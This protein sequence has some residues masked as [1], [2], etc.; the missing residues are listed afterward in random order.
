MLPILGAQVVKK[1]FA[2]PLSAGI[3]AQYF[4]QESD[5]VIENL[6]V[7]FN[8]GTMYN[9]D[10]IIRFDDAKSSAQAVTIRPDIWLFPFLNVYLIMGQGKSST[11]VSAKVMLPDSSNQWNEVTSFSTTANFDATT[12]GF[13]ITPTMGIWGWWLA[14]DMNFTWNDI[15]ALNEPAFAYVFGPRFG[16]T[17]KID[18]EKSFTFWFGGFR[19]NLAAQTS[20]SLSLSELFDAGEIQGK[21][22]E[23]YTNLGNAEENIESW[24][25]GLSESEQ[26]NPANKAKYEVANNA[27]ET[28]G[29]LLNAVDGAVNQIQGSTVQYSLEKKPKDPWNF[30]I[31]SQFQINKHF[32]IRAEYG[33]LGSRN[34]F[35]TGIQYRFGL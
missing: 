17:I 28:A 13:G 25:D 18:E 5:L 35:T 23:G 34:H 11:E 10:Q 8:N 32:M 22:D 3:S 30:I 20:G 19:L 1:G 12:T 4:W 7:G 14:L 29:N 2:L 27:L 21:I 16:K 6:M 15:S 9:I 26:N 31:G 24:W 33:F